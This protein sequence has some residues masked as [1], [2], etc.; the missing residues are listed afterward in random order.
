MADETYEM[1]LF[2]LKPGI[3]RDSMRTVSDQANAWLRQQPG[4]LSRE[5]LE[6]ESGQWVDML[7]WASLDE[8]LAAA[9]AFID[10]PVAAA[11]MALVDEESIRMLHPRRFATYN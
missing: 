8:A 6:D 10:T 5:V 11:Y 3:D 1:V 9:E 4:F 2:R 7:R